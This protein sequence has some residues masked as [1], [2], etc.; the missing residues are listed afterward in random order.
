MT[1]RIGELGWQIL[2]GVL[3]SLGFALLLKLGALQPLEQIAYTALFHLRGQQ[4]WDDR[5][6]V[7]AIDDSSISRL[8]RFPWSRQRYVELL[9]T[10]ET[11]N[12]SL[13]AFNLLWSESSPHDAQLAQAMTQNGRVVLA[14][15]W[16]STGLPLIAVPNLQTAAIASGHV[17]KQQ[18]LDGIT[19]KVDLQLQ[20]EPA[21]GVA[22]AK[23]YALVQENIPLPDLNQSLW[24]NWVGKTNHIQQYAFAD[25]I[26]R[27]IAPQNFQNKIVLVGVTATGID[28]LPTPFDQNPPA[29][30]V[31]LQATLV[32]NLLQHNWLQLPASNWTWLILL[33]SG[34]GFSWLLYQ[35]KES[36]QFL[37]W[38]GACLGWG[39][40]VVVLFTHAYWLPIVLP[41][42]L[43]TTTAGGVFVGERLRMGALLRQR[44][45]QLWETHH[46]DLVNRHPQTTSPHGQAAA[47]NL[48]QGVK[49]LAFLAEQLGRSQSTQAA[50]A[51]SLSTGLVATDWDGLIWFCNP[52]AMDWLQVQFGG[53]LA[54]RLVP[55]WLAETEWQSDLQALKQFFP[56]PEHEIQRGDR[57]F[58]IKLEPLLY[59]IFYTDPGGSTNQTGGLLLVLEEIT[60][61]KQAEFALAQ[62]IEELQLVAQLKD[63]FLSTVSH[64]LR[65][66]MANMRM[67]IEMLKVAK[68]PEA[69]QRYLTILQTECDR[70]IELIEDLLDLQ[71]LE[72][73]VHAQNPSEIDLQIWLP[74]ILAPFHDQ[75][76]KH[77]Q[78]LQLHFSP[79]TPPIRLDQTSLERI[80]VELVNNA[81][82]YTPPDNA[83][84]VEVEVN[85]DVV[86][87][88]Q[89]SP[90]TVKA[91][92]SDTAS[93]PY[94]QIR[95]TNSGTE[96]AEAHLERVFEKF[97][98]VPKADP[99]KRGGTGLGLALVKKLVDSM[100][101]TIHVNSGDGQTRFT[102]EIPLTDQ[103]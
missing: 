76:R 92:I 65:S 58:A 16:D 94:L 61:R 97:Y 82:K 60:T 93:P 46:R 86:R 35:Q 38:L 33:L 98:R 45:H 64:E 15:G 40:L 2:P 8:G 42:C 49:E 17:L 31:F 52:T 103:K 56:V 18:D 37:I 83:I 99:W 69:S 70:E 63:D 55:E 89:T 39:V 36:R 79:Q 3:A 28:P 78:T 51:R 30:G 62:Q 21:L 100:N 6:V 25:V 73:G 10:L 32:N 44:L 47:G 57:W 7:I 14:E 88:A 34:P 4:E 59:Q 90:S 74:A 24:L 19:R 11:A 85:R 84:T 13:I 29:S 80:L 53:Y 77:Q 75:A 26:Q 22:I 72:A 9:N 101:G 91:A 67:A 27:K 1:W 12:P 81:C 102:V 68:S 20:G 5:V 48:V 71:R 41:L 43:L 96:I 54:T 50:I 23:S 87:D 66:P 95:V